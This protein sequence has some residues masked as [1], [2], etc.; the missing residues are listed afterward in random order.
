MD[1]APPPS[2]VPA[3]APS[4]PQPDVL[5]AWPPAAQWATAFLLGVAGTLL[6]VHSFSYLR[7]TTRP[8]DHAIGY[9]V[10]VNEAG[11]AELIQLPGIGNALAQRIE[12]HRQQRGP[13]RNLEE[14]RQVPGIGPTTLERLRPWVRVTEPAPGP[15]SIPGPAGSRRPLSKKE[16]N[17]KEVIDIN[18]A[19]GEELQRLPGIG[20]KLSQRILDERG[21]R[22]FRSVDELRRVP[23]IGPK[24]LERLRPYVTVGGEPQRVAQRK[25]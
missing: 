9:Q 4:P 2:P 6:V 17:L 19:T 21:K 24:I 14:M 23:G 3:P 12:E 15:G 7:W 11:R 13:F 16:E 5:H 20:P 1:A 8:T 10:D 22:P 25:L 18:R